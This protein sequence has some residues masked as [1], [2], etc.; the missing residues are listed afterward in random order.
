MM[1][2]SHRPTIQADLLPFIK[3]LID[4]TLMQKGPEHIPRSGLMLTMSITLW[5]LS[6][7]AAVA[8]VDQMSESVFFVNVLS[9]MTGVA[10]FAAIIVVTGKSS[11]LL[12]TT[13]AII[14]I[15]AIV[16]FAFVAEYLLVTPLLGKPY[17]VLFGTLILLWSVPVKGNIIA[18]AIESH[19]YIGL[20]LAVFVFCLQYIISQLVT[21][22]A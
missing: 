10:C 3:T 19:W 17:A 1:A 13:S 4:I 2:A 14:G 22:Q 12:Q 7:L 11:R 8:L 5:L 20:L 6:A 15:G 21:A 9:K 18:R 16:T